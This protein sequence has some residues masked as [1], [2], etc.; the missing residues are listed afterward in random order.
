MTTVVTMQ[1][2]SYNESP[3]SGHTWEEYAISDCGLGCKIYRSRID[4]SVM[5]LMHNSNYGCRR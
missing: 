3:A 2:Y 1:E 5:I 4:H